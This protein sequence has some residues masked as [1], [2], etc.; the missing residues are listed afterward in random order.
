MTS[1]TS[2]TK[3][4]D[5]F[6]KKFQKQTDG[7]GKLLDEGIF[8]TVVVL[9]CLGINTRQS[10]EGHLD[11]GVA[12][13]WVDIIPDDA[14][15]QKSGEKRKKAWEIRDKID[16]L[17]KGIIDIKERNSLFEQ[18]YKLESEARKPLL[19]VESQAQSLLEEFYKDR[20]IKFDSHL[21]IQDFGTMGR[22]QSHGAEIQQIRTSKQK[23]AHLMEYQDEMA[24]FTKYLIDK[25]FSN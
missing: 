16:E 10:C 11:H 15:D 13:P 1:N 25:F 9:N 2:K 23:A 3:I 22:I 12:G 20:P 5:Q 17:E 7:L 18:I 6:E 24:D 8:Q 21:V 4:W 19:E 14:T